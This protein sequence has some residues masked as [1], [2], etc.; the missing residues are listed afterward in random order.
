M[1]H[2]DRDVYLYNMCNV[3]NKKHTNDTQSNRHSTHSE[4]VHNQSYPLPA[5]KQTSVSCQS[6][7]VT[8]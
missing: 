3:Y 8:K 7:S 6:K 1:S 4:H 2:E 5:T